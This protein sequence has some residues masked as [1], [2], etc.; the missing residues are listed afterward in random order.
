M[1]LLQPQ[2]GETRRLELTNA[3]FWLP[4]LFKS[5]LVKEGEDFLL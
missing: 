2:L 1:T 5:Q 3:S 4:S